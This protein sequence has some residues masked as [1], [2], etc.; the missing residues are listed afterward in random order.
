MRLRGKSVLVTGGAGFIGSHLSRRLL[1]E[2][3]RVRVLDNLS[4]GNL[5]NLPAREIDFIN[6]D[7]RCPDDVAGAVRGAEIV[8]H[9]AAQI[10][11]VRSV[12]SPVDDFEI[13]ARG[14]VNL[15]ETSLRSGVNKFVFAST[16][17]YGNA[18]RE[19]MPESY[20]TLKEAG[21]LLSPYAAAK[22]SGEAYCKVYNDER[23]LKTVRLRFFNV[24]G[25]RQ[26]TRS[27]SGAVAIFTRRALSGKPIII[28]GDGTRTR[29]FVYV[30]DVVEANIRAVR[31]DKAAGKV[32]NIGTGIE[33][34][35]KHLAEAVRTTAG[36]TVP[37]EY[38]PQRA[39]D[40]QR[41]RADLTLSRSVLGYKPA[42]EIHKGLER[43]VAWVRNGVSIDED[44]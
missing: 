24:Y 13:N 21:S 32:F 2:G 1:R 11:P 9:L 19:K 3:A 42:V 17:V 8:F 36:S 7:V 39:A 15:L 38:S 4:N 18:F 35:I 33:T 41:A 34:S 44:S 27:E 10:N 22:V 23:G 43:Y 29:D 6:G 37:I 25:P 16:N 31:E 5:D 30:D 26:T 40:F 28:F 12:Q 20:P 14:T